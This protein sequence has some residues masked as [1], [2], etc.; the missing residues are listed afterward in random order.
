LADQRQRRGVRYP[1]AFV[2]TVMT[3]AKLAG[4][5][6]PQAFADWVAWRAAL[7]VKTFE[8]RRPTMPSH[9]TYRRVVR[10][11][12]RPDDWEQAV[13]DFL[14]ALPQAGAPTQVPLDGKTL[15]GSLA[16]S[17]SRGLHLLAAYL[18]ILS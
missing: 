6:T 15:R 7:F 9:H 11:A 8:L 14:S 13:R 2:L 16:W 1:L 18:S 12:V 17:E 3:L 10:T 4:A 5:D